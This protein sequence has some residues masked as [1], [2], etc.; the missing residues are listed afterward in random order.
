MH[1]LARIIHEARAAE[2][3]DFTATANFQT[4]T[5][6]FDGSTA[7]YRAS[8]TATVSGSSFASGTMT[9]EDQPFS[10]VETGSLRGNFHGSGGNGMAGVIYSNDGLATYRGGFVRS[11]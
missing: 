4:G 9:I 3:G 6:N 5:I 1:R 2:L 11:R 10:I 8:G 7:S